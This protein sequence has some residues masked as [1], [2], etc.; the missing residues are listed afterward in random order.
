MADIRMTASGSLNYD[1]R[2]GKEMGGLERGL[3]GERRSLLIFAWLLQNDSPTSRVKLP[4][5]VAL[6]DMW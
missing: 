1:R 5:Q 3:D 2:G 4:E 6:R